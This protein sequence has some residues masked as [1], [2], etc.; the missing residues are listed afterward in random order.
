[1]LADEEMAPKIIEYLRELSKP[2]GTEIVY[3]DGV[4]QIKL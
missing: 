4:G 2:Y 3:E 1:M